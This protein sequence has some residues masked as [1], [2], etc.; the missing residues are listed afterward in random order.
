VPQTAA[1][2]PCRPDGSTPLGPGQ[3]RLRWRCSHVRRTAGRL[4]DHRPRSGLGR[5]RHGHSAGGPACDDSGALH[6]ERRHSGC[7]RRAGSDPDRR[8]RHGGGDG[9]A[10]RRAGGPAADIPVA[11]RNPTPTRLHVARPHRRNRRAAEGAPAHQHP[12]A[13]SAGPAGTTPPPD[14]SACHSSPPA[15]RHPAAD[16]P[17]PAATKDQ[18]SCDQCRLQPNY[19]PPTPSASRI[20]PTA[21]AFT[22]PPD[23]CSN[24]KPGLT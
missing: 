12:R 7:R 17:Q 19:C 23:R 22:S 6:R 8:R 10:G 4:G 14:G 11:Q 21:S 24:H 20:R 9:A 16:V 2:P 18:G 13:T 5:G 1:M 3:D 15:A